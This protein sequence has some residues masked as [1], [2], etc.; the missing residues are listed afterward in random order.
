[1]AGMKQQ[2]LP[3]CEES[4]GAALQIDDEKLSWQG[5]LLALECRFYQ[6]STFF[7]VPGWRQQFALISRCSTLATETVRGRRQ[8]DKAG[9]N[10]EESVAG[11]HRAAGHFRHR[12]GHSLG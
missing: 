6:T 11:F 4:C 2:R 1:M 7:V 12:V 10:N 3:R 8:S 9:K 5:L